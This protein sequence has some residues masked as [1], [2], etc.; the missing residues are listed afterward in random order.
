MGAGFPNVL[1]ALTVD[2]AEVS[3]SFRVGE[4]DI[5]VTLTRIN[6]D[7]KK[8]LLSRLKSG[9]LTTRSV[10]S[11]RRSAY[12][13]AGAARKAVKKVCVS[14]GEQGMGHVVDELERLEDG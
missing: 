12:K 3:K 10:D 7:M 8:D 1:E 2:L 6:I 5:T 9:K 11:Q 13:R 14:V 4:E